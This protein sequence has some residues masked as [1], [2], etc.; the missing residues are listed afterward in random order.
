MKRLAFF[1]VLIIA[2]VGFLIFQSGFA[3]KFKQRS[4]PSTPKINEVTK[5]TGTAESPRETIIAENLDTP[6]AIEF[7][8]DENL[9]VTERGGTVKLIEADNN[10][11]VTDV[12]RIP[13]AKEIGEGGLLGIALHPD[14]ESNNHVYF[15]Y[16][17]EQNGQNTMNRV[18]R[19]KFKDNRLSDEKI[20]VDR[21]PGAGNHNGGRIKFGPDKFLYIA[22]GDAQVPS[23]AQ[24]RNSLAGKILRVTDEGKAA[25]GNPFNNQVFSYG[26]RNTQGI[27][28][29]STGELWQTEHGRSAPTGYDEINFIESGKNYGWPDIE[30]DEGRA[31]MVTPI[32]NSGPTTTWAPASAAYIGESL[33]FGGLRGQTLYEAVIK[34][35]QV[36]EF[37]EHFKGQY[38]RIREV[39]V[40]PDGML[41]I[42]TSNRDGR[43]NPATG[44]DKIIRVN[45]E[46]L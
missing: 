3:S 23:L 41:Y 14:F 17:Y 4:T 1:V 28:W 19:M 33:F 35:N 44:D 39:I 13:D 32:R 22:T 30:G 8:P 27:A 43:G 31:G 12:G 18:V 15:Y 38:G 6:W 24:D 2:L 46:K 40:G 42:T 11:K 5:L 7:L 9:L 21:I 29:N 34:N 45:P 26:H 10:Y 20:I 36:S 25:P 37:K 16:T